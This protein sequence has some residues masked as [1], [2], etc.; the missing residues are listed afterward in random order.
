LELKNRQM[1]IK[2]ALQEAAS[3]LRGQ[4]IGEGRVEAEL[5]LA[6]LLQTGRPY[7]YAHGETMLSF[8]QSAD[9]AELCRRRAAGEPLAY[10][11][12]EKEFMGLPFY[13]EAGV[14]IPRPETELLV[15]LVLRWAREAENNSGDAVNLH[16]LEL[17]TGSGNIAVSLAYYLPR[18]YLVAVDADAK[19]LATACRNSHRHGV[20]ARINFLQGH[21]YRA[22]ETA[23]GVKR[24]FR[25]I[26][27]N[28]PYIE[29]GMLPGLPVEVRQEP[30]RAL[31]GGPD[32]LDAYREIIA[33]ALAVLLA[34]GLLALELG[35]GQAA[36]VKA[37]AQRAGF[38]RAEVHKDYAGIERVLLCF[39]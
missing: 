14:F 29:E 15:E 18:A 22:L 17:G 1:S 30:R 35:A 24:H 20:A 31:C 21:Y 19:A 12:R 36:E 11:S 28:P 3:F 25:I 6:L 5:L 38:A 16:I 4:G 26:V 33:G 7:L 23:A 9:Y 27:A 2:E 39:T 34:P 13:V 8:T 10:I 37:L 32:G